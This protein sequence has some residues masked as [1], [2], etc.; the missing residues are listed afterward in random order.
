MFS[1]AIPFDMEELSL[2]VQCPLDFG[3]QTGSI[4]DAGLSLH[5]V[6]VV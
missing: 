1:F 2:Q 4:R 3:S 5:N 6:G